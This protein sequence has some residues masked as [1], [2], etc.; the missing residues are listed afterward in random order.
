MAEVLSSNLSEPIIILIDFNSERFLQFKLIF[1]N[2]A[3]VILPLP[4]LLVIKKD[5]VEN[6]L[7]SVFIL[8]PLQ[9]EKPADDQERSKDGQR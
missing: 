4:R 7:F 8:S 5:K 1:T 3:Q 2:Q 6:T 9:C